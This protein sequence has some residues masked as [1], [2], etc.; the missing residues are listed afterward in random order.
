LK[1]AHGPSWFAALRSRVEALYLAHE[2]PWRGSGFSGP[3]ARWVALR[4]PVADCI[5]RSGSFLDVG[6]A[7]GYLLECVRRWTGER[8]LAFDLYGVDLSD[9]LVAL[10]RVRMPDLADRLWVANAFTW[11]P[12]RRFDFV[13]TELV[14]VP[15]EL[16]ADYLKHLL[17]HYVAAGGAL[18]VANY[19][20]EHPDPQAHILDG[21]APTTNVCDRLA[22]LG[23]SVSG[24]RDGFDEVKG[25]KTR[26]AIVRA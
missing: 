1:S 21:A 9:A 19:L 20:E 7:N 15:S 23:F 17:E 4:R 25:R 2:E 26:I 3:E 13:R 8:G 11:R 24:V 18:L 10:A 6:C 12:P 5:D 22:E 14:Y 16:E